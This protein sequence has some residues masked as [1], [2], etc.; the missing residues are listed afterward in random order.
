LQ[1]IRNHPRELTYLWK[2]ST[3][4]YIEDQYWKISDDLHILYPNLRNLVAQVTL[5]SQRK[6]D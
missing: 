1:L 5:P 6:P 3:G 2:I 4:K